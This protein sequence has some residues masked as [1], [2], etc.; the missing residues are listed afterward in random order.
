MGKRD[1]AAKQMR[2]MREN[3]FRRQMAELHA[4][5]PESTR[6]DVHL[7]CA[8]FHAQGVPS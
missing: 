4:N 3:Y 8:F 1:V 7:G 2:S 5:R 6:N